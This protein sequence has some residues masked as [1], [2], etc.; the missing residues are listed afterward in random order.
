MI[1]K[2]AKKVL[3]KGI[4]ASGGIA[5][6]KVYRITD[7]TRPAAGRAGA[8]IVAAFTT[9]VIARAI[10]SSAGVICEKGGLTSHGAIIAR[11][12]NIPCLVS[13][14]NAL[15]ILHDGQS[16]ILDADRGIVYAA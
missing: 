12:L 15:A 1:R 11:E 9:P 16:V 14:K 7:A 4:R 8:I 6:G 13:A 5:R 3:L 2:H 10:I